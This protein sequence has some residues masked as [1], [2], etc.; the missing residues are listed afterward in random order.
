[1][2]RNMIALLMISGLTLFSCNNRVD[3]DQVFNKKSDLLLLHYDF[4]TDVD[5]LHS[6]AAFGTLIGDQRFADL[7]YHAVAGTYGIQDGLYVPPNDLM[8]FIF[9]NH[10]SDAHKNLEQALTEV[11]SIVLETLTKGGNIWIAEGGQSDFSASLIRMVSEE[12]PEIISRDRFHLVQHADWNEQVTHP[13]SLAYVNKYSN[14]H[15]IPD[16]NAVGNGT[17]GFRS[18]E[19]ITLSEVIKDERILKTWQL[20][21]EIADRHNG[22]EGRY[23]NE[24]IDKGG[25]DFSDFAEVCY[26]LAL[27][28]LEESMDFFLM[29][30]QP[31]K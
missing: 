15:R 24:S 29:I 8:Q 22:A 13:E 14:Y 23:L 7:N 17:P 26:I 1:M 28:Q 18:H 27:D 4:K 3:E 5:D 16:G 25:L 19:I 31:S 12:V 10:W 30:Q 9:G 20:A 6:A 21:K 2:T 11:K